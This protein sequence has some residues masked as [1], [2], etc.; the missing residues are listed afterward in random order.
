MSPGA[1]SAPVSYVPSPSA[2]TTYQSIIPNVSYQQQ[3]DYLKTTTDQLN[4]SL[5]AL[6]QQSG[7]P[8][9]IGARQAGYRTAQSGAYAASLPK[10]DTWLKQVTGTTDPFAQGRESSTMQNQQD[11]QDYMAKLKT[12]QTTPGYQ[13]PNQTPSWASTD[14]SQFAVKPS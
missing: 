5:Q 8:A 11:Q 13:F 3:A 6:Y 14:P 9:E 2:A 7:T 1:P 4:Q 10:G 12:A